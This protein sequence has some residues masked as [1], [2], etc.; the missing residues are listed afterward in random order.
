MK[1]VLFDYRAVLW[2]SFLSG[3]RFVDRK[4][5]IKELYDLN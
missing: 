5:A 1:E 4:V 3:K 2:E